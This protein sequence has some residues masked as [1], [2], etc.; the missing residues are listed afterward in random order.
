MGLFDRDELSQ[1]AKNEKK[2]RYENLRERADAYKKFWDKNGV[3]Q[4]KTEH[5][6][7]LHRT[8]GLQVQFIVAFDDLTK[9][10]Y[11]LMA[12]DEGSEG[13]LGPITGGINSYFYFQKIKYV[14]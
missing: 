14:S 5:I 2:E 1:V 10:G 13:S 6:A 3:I 8:V 11:R 7:I 4:Y 9:E 12:H